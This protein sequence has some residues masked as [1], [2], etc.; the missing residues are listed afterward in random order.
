MPDVV[1][2]CECGQVDLAPRPDGRCRN[3]GPNGAHPDCGPLDAPH[4]R[5]FYPD[6]RASDLD[7]AERL[8]RRVREVWRDNY[9]PPIPGEGASL[10]GRGVAELAALLSDESETNV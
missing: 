8:L 10:R 2:V 7:E 9:L 6:T 3:W 5:P 1:F 4:M